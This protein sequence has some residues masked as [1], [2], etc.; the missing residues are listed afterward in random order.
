MNILR[1]PVKCGC[2]GPVGPQCCRQQ[3]YVPSHWGPPWRSIGSPSLEQIKQRLAS[4]TVD[5]GH[6]LS[7]LLS[8]HT[9]TYLGHGATQ[10]PPPASFLLPLSHLHYVPGSYHSLD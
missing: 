2:L 6:K 10:L 3:S 5:T 4:K 1:I 7:A 8:P 9:V